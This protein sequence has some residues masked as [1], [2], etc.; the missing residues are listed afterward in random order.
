MVASA[1]AVKQMWGEVNRFR[2]YHEVGT[3]SNGLDRDE[4]ER[5]A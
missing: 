3:A 5:E 1:G 4:R 2:I